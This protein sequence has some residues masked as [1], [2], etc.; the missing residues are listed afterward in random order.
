[1][2]SVEEF[3][4]ANF[5]ISFL[6]FILLF[7]LSFTSTSISCLHIS[8]KILYLFFST[9]KCKGFNPF[10]YNNL[11]IYKFTTSRWN[12]RLRLFAFNIC[13]K[14]WKFS[15]KI[16]SLIFC[17]IFYFYYLLFVSLR[18]YFY[19]KYLHWSFPY[20]ALNKIKINKYI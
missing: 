15:I 11:N 19:Y 4:Q 1:M 13:T 6:Q 12:S 5:L 9:I 16:T 20:L 17:L 2:Q 8:S 14:P 10:F 18:I 3:F 7:T